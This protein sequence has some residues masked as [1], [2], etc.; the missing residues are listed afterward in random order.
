MTGQVLK[1]IFK[2]DKAYLT[3]DSPMTFEQLGLPEIAETFKSAAY[4]QIKVLNYR[5]N[6][7]KIFCE[8]ISYH[9]GKTEFEHNQKLLADKLNNLQIVIFRS[10]DT[11]CLLKTLFEE[12]P[13]SFRPQYDNPITRT[14]NKYVSEP[15]VGE[16][17]K[18]TMKETFF[19]PLKNVRFKSGSV[20]FDKNFKKIKK[21][22]ELTIANDD[23]KEE[24]DAVK[25]YFANVLR[26][27]KI[28]VTV[29][30]EITD[31]EISK[32]E[33][34]S[35]EIARID[36]QLIDNVKFDFVKSTINKKRNEAN[37]K[38]LFTMEEYFTTFADEKIKSNPFYS[39]EGELFE[40][41]LKIINTKH[42]KHLR[43]LSNKHSHE[44]M[45]LR[46][47]HNPFSFIFLVKGNRNYHIIW[48]TL[49]TKE[50]TYVWHIQKDIKE[51]KMYLHKIEDIIN[52]IKV[53][54]KIAYINSTEDE[55]IRI[56]HD[57]SD[58]VDG[59]IKWKNKMEST[60][61]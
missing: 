45:K 33:T 55:F 6:E 28:E 50:A 12:S 18:Q 61:I 30:L 5:E 10:I 56:W 26:T 19:I 43:F 23:I 54:G 48:E 60:L 13:G 58:P 8:I 44:I 2:R 38:N 49:D 51:L 1:I 52:L 27:K 14:Q 11:N 40:D 57:Y 3:I 36:K 42:Y 16:P 21:K 35:P 29:Y 32:I 47:V 39:N 46:F 15:H 4:W 41:L 31:N 53:Q 7:K 17:I 9:V 34:K 20:S 59:F 22:L 24:F 37:D 25:N